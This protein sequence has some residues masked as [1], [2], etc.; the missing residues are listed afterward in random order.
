[1]SSID[2]VA[3][4]LRIVVGSL[5]VAAVLAF[6]GKEHVAFIGN[7]SDLPSALAFLLFVA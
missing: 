3:I 6:F 7:V 2:S 4:N 1:M 5:I